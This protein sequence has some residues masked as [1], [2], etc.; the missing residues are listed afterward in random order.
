M[1]DLIAWLST[2]IGL[3]VL[4][5]IIYLLIKRNREQ[6]EQE[7]QEEEKKQNKTR[8]RKEKTMIITETKITKIKNLN[9]KCPSNF[10]NFTLY[11]HSARITNNN[12]WF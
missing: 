1:N 7:K 11:P 3:L 8:K 10:S 9:I 2:P 12:S 6:E 5:G 4:G